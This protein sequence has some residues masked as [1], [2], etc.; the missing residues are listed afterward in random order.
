LICSPEYNGSYPALLK[1]AIDWASSPVAGDP[2]WSDGTLP[3]RGKVVGMASASP[4][5]LGGLRAQSHLAPLLLNLQCWLAPVS[6][7]VGQA[8]Q[9]F[10]DAGRLQRPQDQLGMKAVLEQVLWAA[11]RLSA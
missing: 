2:V 4:G 5:G 11:Q 1:N 10:D 8:G 6:H 3:F 9:A 7:A